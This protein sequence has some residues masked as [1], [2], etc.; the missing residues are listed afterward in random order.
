MPALQ[1]ETK[2]TESPASAGIDL[3]DVCEF[4]MCNF[5]EYAKSKPETIALCCIGIGFIL[6][7]KLKP[8]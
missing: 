2:K 1:D 4:A 6:G 7:W 8:W 3:H 5:R